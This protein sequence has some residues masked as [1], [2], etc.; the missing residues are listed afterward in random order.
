MNQTSDFKKINASIFQGSAVG[1][2]LFT[3][4]SID[5]KPIDSN[6]FLDKYADDSYLIV[7]SNNEISINRELS[8]IETWASVNNLQLNKSKTK[9]I[10]FATSTAGKKASSNSEP[11]PGIDRVDYI[12]ILG[13][14]LT[15]TFSMSLHI[16]NLLSSSMQGFYALKTLKSSGLNNQC[17]RQIFKSTIIP[18]LTYALPAW[19]GFITQ[20]DENRL[21][22]IF[23]KALKWG[24]L[25]TSDPSLVYIMDQR[26]KNLFQKVIANS[27]HTLHF[28]LPPAKTRQHNLRPKDHNRQLPIKDNNLLGK[29]FLYRM[30]YKSVY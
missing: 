29:N 22:S 19:R 23:R 27:L 4:N 25:T 9:E 20:R 26:D 18:K 24:Y 2:T 30:L 1:P 3:L 15:G 8:N 7:G 28:L 10:L 12:K 6:N 21:A 11:I 16:D 13:I 17:T 14:T 5:L